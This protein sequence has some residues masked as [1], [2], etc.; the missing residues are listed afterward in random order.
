MSH[1]KEVSQRISDN[2]RYHAYL[3]RCWREEN[4]WRFSLETIGRRPERRG[5]SDFNELMTQL[6]G[7]LIETDEQIQEIE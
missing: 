6:K 1:N 4:G 2:L 3:I 5:F 7:K